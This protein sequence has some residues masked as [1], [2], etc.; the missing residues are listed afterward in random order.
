MKKKI[1]SIQ[2]GKAGEREFAHFLKDQH[3]IEARRGV[4]Y[5]GG[6][7]SPDVVTDLTGVHFEVKRVETFNAYKALEQAEKDA[8]KDKVP[9]V[10][11]R[12]SRKDWVLVFYAKDLK[13]FS[14]AITNVKE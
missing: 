12:R 3:G 9:I 4:Q 5:Q 1:N 11:H 2:K 14:K 13:N 6:T 10:A 8:G 7:D